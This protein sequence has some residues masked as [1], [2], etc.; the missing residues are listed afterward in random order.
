MDQNRFIQVTP[1][2]QEYINKVS[3][4]ESKILQ[5]LRIENDNKGH[6]LQSSPDQTQFLALLAKIINAKKLMEIGTYKGYTTLALAEAIDDDGE[7]ISCEINEEWIDI[8][9]KYWIEAGVDYKITTKIAPA[10]DTLNNLI[11]QGHSNSFDFIF[12]D[13]DKENS[14]I[15]YDLSF[16]LI[17]KNGLI[18]IDNTLWYG[19]VIKP[20]VNDKMTQAIRHLNLKLMQDKRVSISLLPLRDGLTIIQKNS[21]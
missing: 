9:K 21:N 19:N 3:V 18:I 17:H 4:R 20:Q 1:E 15:Y 16:Q 10:S 2:L 14:S 7:I 8:A 5:K 11:D 12:I 13:A 6:K